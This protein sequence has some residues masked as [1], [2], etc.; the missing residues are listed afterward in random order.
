M[1]F[2][3][4]GPEAPLLT[5]QCPPVAQVPHFAPNYA[6]VFALLVLYCLL[7]S[8]VLLMALAAT[9]GGVAFVW[10]RNSDLALPAP[11]KEPYS[12]EESASTVVHSMSC[13]HARAVGTLTPRAQMLAVGVATLPFYYLGAAGST[14]FWLIGATLSVVLGHAALAPIAAPVMLQV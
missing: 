12:L 8:P 6:L 9:L 3:P 10:H 2:S 4:D 5:P 13:L 7:S 1:F 14:V 11:G